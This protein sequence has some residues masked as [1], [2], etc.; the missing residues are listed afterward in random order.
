MYE[1][2]STPF[3]AYLQMMMSSPRCLALRLVLLE[4]GE[5]VP[6]LEQRESPAFYG[7]WSCECFSWC[8]LVQTN[9]DS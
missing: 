2:I 9:A 7:L 5:F 8:V 1:Y 6:R 3:V 4:D